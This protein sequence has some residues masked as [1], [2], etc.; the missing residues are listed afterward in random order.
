M[1]IGFVLPPATSSKRNFA[2]II[3][4]L[5]FCLAL[6]IALDA[7]TFTTLVNFNGTDGMYP[8][9][10]LTQGLDGYIY[11]T[12]SLGGTGSQPAGTVF[13][14][15]PTGVLTT[16]YNFCSQPD[17]VDGEAPSASLVQTSD[18][19]LYGTTGGGGNLNGPPCG[20]IGCGT[21]FAIS[22]S[23]ALAT[24]YKFCSQSNC[25]DGT[26]PLGGLVQASD[27]NFYGT[28]SG[29]GAHAFGTIFRITP[30][31]TFTTLYN[32]C[33]QPNCADG[34]S[35]SGALV[36]GADGYL[37]G[38]TAAGG[39]ANCIGAAGPGCGTLFK[40]SL[41]GQFASLYAFC[42]QGSCVDGY[43]PNAPL[44]QAADGNLYGTT[45]AG[46]FNSS[47]V[48]FR[49]SPGGSVTTVYN[50]CSQ[51]NCADGSSPQSGLI[52]GTDGRFYGTTRYGG[53]VSSNCSGGCGTLFKLTTGGT[54]ATLHAFIG[55]DGSDILNGLLEAT[56]GVFYGVANA[57]G[58]NNLGTVF[59]LSTGAAP[60][61]VTRPSSAQIGAQIEILGNN[62]NQAAA[63]VFNGTPATQFQ[64][65]SPS[66]ITATVP[67]G[68]STGK[69]EVGLSGTSL[70]TYTNFDVTGPF[71]FIPSVS[72][73]RL[74][75]TRDTGGPIQGG[76]SRNFNVPQLGC[77]I[78][79]GAAAYSLNV[80]VVPQGSLGY[81]TIWPQGDIQ[82][83]AST[84][85]SRDGRVKANAAI[86]PA[87][88][89]AVSV[90]VSDTTNIILDINGYFVSNGAEP[91]EFYSLTPC[92]IVDTRNGQDG[93]TLQAGMERDYNIAGTC[94]IPSTATAYSFNVTAIPPSGG[95]DYLTVWPKGQ[96]RPVV[97]TLNDPT[98]TIVANAAIVPAG[99]NNATAFYAHNNATDLLLDVNGYF[100]PAGTGGLSL[101]TQSPCRVLDTRQSGGAFSGKITV[102]VEGRACAPSS[103]AQ[104]YVFNATV[105]PPGPMPYLTLWP[106][107]LAQ[108]TVSTLNAKDGFVTSN[109]AIVPTS[110]GS[111]DAYAAALTQLIL[112][113]SGYFAPEPA[114]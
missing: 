82:P 26:T 50:F 77:D 73:C 74:I 70:Y 20:Q 6:T 45:F 72:P 8:M 59:S 60:F 103:M 52:V 93:G 19:T 25:A 36:Q 61:I 90:Y 102:N 87:G 49:M 56:N 42:A 58:T 79:N 68:A 34:A 113:I 109:M 16:I 80:T 9:A 96:M 55:T 24:L 30:A 75:D 100:A 17:C 22:P 11:G 83:F 84:M 31:G 15:L 62:L 4:L 5:G 35:P 10:S 28:T 46:G 94:G 40:V 2:K 48:V 64:I 86:V 76:T 3:F 29:G 95:L 66:E 71:Q 114:R 7:Q 23:G 92:R 63:V 97:S 54:L 18:G 44:V 110:N 105:A 1:R 32:F 91:Y 47:G 81:L 106:D 101:Y 112:D 53:T 85:N 107:G 27:G 14:M 57:G 39:I 37:Y 43:L 12:T 108:P 89:N 13:K 69:V 21:A 65:V 38:T 67:P 78:P 51:A 88:N 99:Q 41:S 104:A 111:I 33:S 98:G